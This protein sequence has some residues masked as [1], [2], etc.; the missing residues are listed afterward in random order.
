[1]TD[2]WREP[3]PKATHRVTIDFTFEGIKGRE[4]YYVHDDRAM[5]WHNGQEWTTKPMPEGIAW[6][7]FEHELI[8][9]HDFPFDWEDL[10]MSGDMPLDIKTN[11]TVQSCE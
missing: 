5:P 8:F 9:D 10:V 11:Y 2:C 4:V 6:R 3:N 7:E 1:M